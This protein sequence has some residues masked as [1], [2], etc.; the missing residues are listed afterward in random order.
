LSR[1]PLLEAIHRESHIQAR[2]DLGTSGAITPLALPATADLAFELPAMKHKH[3]R[4]DA[5]SRRSSWPV[6]FRPRPLTLE[7]LALVL[8]SGQ[9]GYRG[10][11]DGEVPMLVHTLLYCV[12][13]HVEGIPPGI[14]A[15]D[16]PQHLLRQIRAGEFHQALQATQA[17][18]LVNAANLS[19]CVIPVGNYMSGFRAYG[20]R[21]YRIQNMEAGMIAQR[22]Y[23]AAAA[24][25]LGCRA[26][27]SYRD[28]A[29]DALLGLPEGYTSLLQ[30][31]ISPL[32]S[33]AQ[34]YGRHDVPITW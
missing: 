6:Q 31:L 17:G 18:L 15:Y 22:M 13:N 7:Q 1:W 34:E 16:A 3:A 25:G 14:Y 24:T 30:V 5:G 11:L 21:W 8:Q 33:A 27:L 2:T 20:D 23:L 26:S 19:L 10:D 29:A 32:D 4:V 12:I 28:E 9:R